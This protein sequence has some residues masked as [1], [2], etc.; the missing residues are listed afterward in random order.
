MQQL[1]GVI[2]GG[3]LGGYD[4]NANANSTPVKLMQKFVNDRGWGQVNTAGMYDWRGNPASQGTVAANADRWSA[5]ASLL[6]QMM[7][8]QQRRTYYH[9]YSTSSHNGGGA[10]GRGE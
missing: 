7:N 6:Q 9:D 3:G 1:L 2:S 8:G 4:M 5:L 10:G